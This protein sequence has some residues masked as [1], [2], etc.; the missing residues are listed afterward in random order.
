MNEDIRS[1]YNN[2]DPIRLI[3][4]ICVIIDYYACRD[5]GLCLQD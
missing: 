4:L 5:Y 1:Q 2:W 3:G